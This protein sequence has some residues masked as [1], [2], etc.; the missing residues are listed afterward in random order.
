MKII[1]HEEQNTEFQRLFGLYQ[2]R[3]GVA[4]KARLSQ[5]VYNYV[6]QMISEGKFEPGKRI[7]EEGLSRPL[8]V[9]HVPVREALEKLEQ[10]GWVQRI[11]GR[12]AC[13]TASASE[14]IKSLYQL[15]EIVESGAVG[16]VAQIIT[17]E[18]L[19]ELK[20]VADLLEATSETKNVDV[21]RDCDSHFH[22]LIVHFTG[23]NRLEDFFEPVILQAGPSYFSFLWLGGMRAL[24]KGK[25]SNDYIDPTSHNIHT[26]IYEAIEVHDSEL[27]E[28]L[29]KSHIRYSYALVEKMGQIVNEIHEINEPDYYRKLRSKVVSVV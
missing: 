1:S 15:R 13:V 17:P 20:K 11:H 28:Q 26:G 5:V 18:Q 8:N 10:H 16:L 2:E 14:S 24:L 25:S 22:R 27:A 21:Y 9:S 4:G 29:V 12:G 19:A 6:V 7:T 3:K 23:N